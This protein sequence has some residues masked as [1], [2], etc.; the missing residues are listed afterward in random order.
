MSSRKRREGD[1]NPGV[2]EAAEEK[3]EDKANEKSR[4]SL[5]VE[6]NALEMQE[7]A[8]AEEEETDRGWR[9]PASRAIKGLRE[10]QWEMECFS[11]KMKA[12]QWK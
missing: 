3:V 2:Q 1:F 11:R 12:C 9:V 7:K 8:K 4:K 10:S 6:G 5:K